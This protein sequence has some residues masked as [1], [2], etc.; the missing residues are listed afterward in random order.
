MEKQE[1]LKR[2]NLTSEHDVWTM[3]DDF[4]AVQLFKLMNHDIAPKQNESVVEAAI[5]YLSRVNK[6]EVGEWINS[7]AYGVIYTTAKRILYRHFNNK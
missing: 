4:Y 5:V 2:F 7:S 1:A 6:D 3:T